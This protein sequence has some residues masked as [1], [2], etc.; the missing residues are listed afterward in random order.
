VTQHSLKLPICS[1]QLGISTSAVKKGKE[2][3]EKKKQEKRGQR[4]KKWYRHGE[5]MMK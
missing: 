2:K 5:E 3:E 1:T 4:R